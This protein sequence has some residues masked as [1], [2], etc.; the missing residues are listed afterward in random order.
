MMTARARARATTATMM[1]FMI[2]TITKTKMKKRKE[3]GSAG[4][5]STGGGGIDGRRR[6]WFLTEVTIPRAV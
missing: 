6:T 1:A 5:D 3:G 4:R 2:T